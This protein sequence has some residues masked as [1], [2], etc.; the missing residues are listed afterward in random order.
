MTHNHK[1]QAIMPLGQCP[2]CDEVHHMRIP[3]M[4]TAEKL[5]A[6]I[7]DIAKHEDSDGYF[8]FLSCGEVL[9]PLLLEMVEFINSI[10][11][12]ELDSQNVIAR[13]ALI[14]KFEEFLK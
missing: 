6:K 4:T 13:Q 3:K 7:R 5:Q 9:S 2:R 14:N 12:R 8:G 1:N 11:L 10:S